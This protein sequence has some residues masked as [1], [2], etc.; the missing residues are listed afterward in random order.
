M[1]KGKNMNMLLIIGVII[2]I[3]V[4]GVA[5]LKYTDAGKNLGNKLPTFIT[6]L[7]YDKSNFIILDDGQKN[8][9][10]TNS[11]HTIL[12]KIMGYARSHMMIGPDQMDMIRANVFDKTVKYIEGKSEKTLIDGLGPKLVE[13]SV[14]ELKKINVQPTREFMEE[15]DKNIIPYCKHYLI[16]MDTRWRFP[17]KGGVDYNQP[18]VHRPPPV[19]SMRKKDGI[20]RPARLTIGNPLTEQVN[21]D[22]MGITKRPYMGINTDKLTSGLRREG[23]ST[24]VKGKKSAD[25]RGRIKS[26]VNRL[27]VSSS[28]KDP[29]SLFRFHDGSIKSV[30]SSGKG[31]SNE[32]IHDSK[33]D[34]YLTRTGDREHRVF[35]KIRGRFIDPGKTMEHRVNTTRQNN[36]IT[37]IVQR[38]G[39]P[40]IVKNNSNNP[41]G[42]LRSGPDHYLH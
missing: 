14:N 15:M 12:D 23:F 19:H 27:A 29:N 30:L 38:D 42:G 32:S 41:L 10:Y 31:F 39:Y 20:V 36:I 18:D 35:K 33:V 21:K 28:T 34:E 13:Y 8:N 26:L 5:F 24:V 11:I 7:L 40:P 37:D 17:L 9:I 3:V 22:H 2:F 1:L 4:G 16:Y 6:N 25:F